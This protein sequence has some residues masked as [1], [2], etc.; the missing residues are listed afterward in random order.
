[1]NR[2][3]FIK[4]SI[5]GGSVL[6]VPGLLFGEELSLK[7]TN[8]Q[9]LIVLQLSGGNDGLNTI[10]PYKNDDYYRLRPTIAIEPKEV[11]KVSSELG[12]HPSLKNIASL[13][14]DGDMSIY[15]Q[16]GYPNQNKSHFRA[17]DI[18]LTAGDSDK[19]Y[20]TGWLGKYLDSNCEVPHS[21]IEIGASLSLALKGEKGL[22]MALTNPVELKRTSD[23]SFFNAMSKV[24]YS[25]NGRLASLYASFKNTKSSVNYLFNQYKNNN[26]GVE[27]LNNQ[28]SNS[29]KT[30]GRLIGSGSESSVYY[31]SL[32]GFDTHGNQLGRQKQLLSVVDSSLGAFVKD[33]KSS[34]NWENTLILVF[35]EFGRRIKENGSK[36]TDHG[37][38]NNVWLLGGDLYKK[39]FANEN[40][41]LFHAEEDDLL[42]KMDF[43]EIYASILKYWLNA[44]SGIISGT[45]NGFR[46]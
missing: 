20:S 39:G 21:A 29:L 25:G 23:T 44:K 13:F 24:D 1:M 6:I 28:L 7:N 9:R 43:R 16:V 46:I 32:G 33:L 37:K 36:G 2:R 18:W 42:H 4:K 41:D 27:Y 14:E 3:S 45:F 30:I 26:S 11:I 35:S 15:N 22:G 40:T 17:T 31:V 8:G 34:G 38:A 5:A 19:Y 10:I 12:M